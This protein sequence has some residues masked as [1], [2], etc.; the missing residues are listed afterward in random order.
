MTY[1]SLA[2]VRHTST[3]ILL[4]LLHAL[5][6]R[7]TIRLERLRRQLGR[8]FLQWP[9][10][11]CSK[12]GRH[13][14]ARHSEISQPEC[15]PCS[16]VKLP[17]YFALN[18]QSSDWKLDRDRNTWVRCWRELLVQASFQT[19]IVVFART[20]IFTRSRSCYD[21]FS[22]GRNIVC[23]LTAWRKHLRFGWKYYNDQK[24]ID[25]QM[26]YT[27]H[28]M[29]ICGWPCSCT[30]MMPNRSLRP[31][32]LQGRQTSILPSTVLLIP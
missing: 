30:S 13:H 4:V 9:T 8:R 3:C 14:W 6:S 25:L 26:S 17:V 7:G 10:M 31:G 18:N 29:R 16:V 15:T 23:L 32:V 2:A 21:Q 28:S 22:T 24:E 1:F 12:L 11:N 19:F 27:T 5:G 20:Q